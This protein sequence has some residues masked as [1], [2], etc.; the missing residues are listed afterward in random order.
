MARLDTNPK[1]NCMKNEELS[2]LLKRFTDAEILHLEKTKSEEEHSLEEHAANLTKCIQEDRYSFAMA[3]LDE[4]PDDLQVADNVVAPDWV[5]YGTLRRTDVKGLEYPLFLPT[6]VNAVLFDMGDDSAHVPNIFQ[7]TILRLLLTMRMRL[8]KVS[9]VDMT[10]GANFREVL[11]I[12]NP[13]FQSALVDSSTSVSKLVANL[14]HELGQANRSFLGRYPNIGAYNTNAKDMATPYHF[15]FIDDFP[16]GFTQQSLDDLHRIIDNGNAS[17]AGIKIFINY[18]SK[19]PAPREFCVSTFQS[20]CACISKKRT[21]GL[22]FARWPMGFPSNVSAEL[23]MNLT[24][25]AESCIDLFNHAKEKKVSYSL[26]SWVEEQFSSSKVWTGDSSDGIN[27]PIGFIS[28]RETFDFYLANDNDSSCNDFFA[29]IAGRSGFGKTVL[30]NN[31]IVNS[32][33]KYSPDDLCLYLAD[34]AEGAGFNI[35]KNLPH[36]KSIMLTNSKEYALRML[37][38][39]VA[40]AK[41]RAQLYQKASRQYGK[42]VTNLA[43]YREVTGKK[44]PRILFVMDEFHYLFLSNDELA[45]EAKHTLS[46]GVKQWRKF[47]ISVILSTQSI[48]GVNF[49]DADN[50]I[51]YRFALNLLEED[52]RTVLR[53]GAAKSL[54]RKGQVIMNNTADGRVDK[55]VQFQSA[56]SARYL[57]YVNYLAELYATRYKTARK[58]MVCESEIGSD[59]ADNA[60]LAERL[61]SDS[62]IVNNQYCDV[63]VGKPDLLRNSH[64][65]IRYRRQAGSN[66]LILGGDFGTLINSVMVQICQIA[67]QSHPNSRYYIVDCFNVGDQFEGSFND[68]SERLGGNFIVGSSS[69]IT[70]FIEGIHEELE[71]RKSLQ[72]EDQMVE[73]RIVL[74]ILNLQNCYALRPASG[75]GFSD[76]SSITKKLAAIITE[77]APLGIHCILHGLSYETVFSSPRMLDSKLLPMFENQIYLKGYNSNRSISNMRFC[78]I[79]DEG[80]MVVINAKV[81]GQE[82]ELCRAYSDLTVQA[83]NELVDYMNYMFDKIANIHVD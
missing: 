54:T 69:S 44:I 22:S 7:N 23:D 58:P 34:F 77:G 59:I 52:S 63:F 10:F 16:N 35:Y 64:T 31:I 30:L 45:I 67:K 72:Q 39:V 61:S 82:Y 51:T 37:E 50:Q 60:E 47:G 11:S 65:R 70:K 75:G 79:E 13:V 27:V 15:V 19:S 53:N 43:Q 14:A 57:D 38:D 55:N 76:Q 33:I 78:S 48:S 8:V 21:G 42:Q 68:I 6:D 28:S 1:F 24:N 9:I 17:R 4:L 66:T 74:S 3:N 49:G 80:Q 5:R 62:F 29:L 81:G 32:A 18:S 83:H 71:R 26:D 20:C 73:E 56:Y 41:K 40:E 25:K 36:V 46:N 12:N 2:I